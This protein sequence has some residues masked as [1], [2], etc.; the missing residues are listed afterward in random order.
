MQYIYISVCL[1]GCNCALCWS[2]IVALKCHLNY[3]V[4][5]LSDSLRRNPC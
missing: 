3:H 5:L 4:E 2:E 1:L